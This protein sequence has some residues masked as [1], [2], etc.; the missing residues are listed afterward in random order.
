MQTTRAEVFSSGGA[1]AYAQ[2]FGKTSGGYVTSIRAITE[3]GLIPQLRELQQRGFKARILELGGGSGRSNWAITETLQAN[4]LTNFDIIGTEGFKKPIKSGQTAKE[5]GDTELR[6]PQ[7]QSL[8]EQIPLKSEAFDTVVGSQVLHWIAPG[9]LSHSFAEACRVLKPEGRLIHASSGILDLGSLNAHHFTRHPFVLDH[10]LPALEKEL[11]TR[12]LWEREKMGKFVP[13]N[14]NVNPAYHNFTPDRIR[15]LLDTSGFTD[16]QIV[17]YM[18]PCDTKE[19]ESRL[20][21][22]AALDMH[23]FAGPFATEVI[24]KNEKGEDIPRI[25]DAVRVEI[26][27]AAFQKAKSEKP[28]L[29]ASFDTQNLDVTIGQP[30][31]NTFGEPVPVIVARRPAK[32]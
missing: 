11:T 18:F 32:S 28:D 23:F 24:G 19:M 17:D 27:Q 31:P 1:E 5:E 16:I 15:E 30:N 6:I 8:A 20:T 9:E 13:W 10:Y 14:P 7:I 3:Q 21:N 22:L 25:T 12:G 29:F 4:G 26:A 2:I